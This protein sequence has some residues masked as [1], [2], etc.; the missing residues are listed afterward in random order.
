MDAVAEIFIRE[1][2]VR[3][4]VGLLHLE[5]FC[6]F[7]ISFFSGFVNA[8]TDGI[9]AARLEAAVLYRKPVHEASQVGNN[10]VLEIENRVFANL[11]APALIDT[12]EHENVSC[13][14]RALAGD[15]HPDAPIRIREIGQRP[16]RIF[17][18]VHFFVHLTVE[19]LDVLQL[20]TRREIHAVRPSFLYAKAL[21]A[22]WRFSEQFWIQGLFRRVAHTLTS[23]YPYS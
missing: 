16:R 19:K 2:D 11:A 18:A 21:V 3:D 17:H 22:L 12:P 8:E 15:A 7:E 23:L 20:V 10:A 5:Q 1:T 14:V 6:D 9:N 4:L 13:F